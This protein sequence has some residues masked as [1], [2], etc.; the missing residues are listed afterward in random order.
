MKHTYNVKISIIS[1]KIVIKITC[2]FFH[3]EIIMKVANTENPPYRPTLPKNSNKDYIGGME[4]I[5]YDCLNEDP[6]NRPNFIIIEK[7]IKDS[8]GYK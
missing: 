1:I 3:T 4:T 7:R 2:L 8:T 5:M 6:Q